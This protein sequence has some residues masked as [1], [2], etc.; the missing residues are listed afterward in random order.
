MP[1]LGLELHLLFPPTARVHVGAAGAR[2]APSPA[3]HRHYFRREAIYHLVWTAPV[4]EVA[5]RLGV[6]DVALAKLCRRAAIPTPG[7]GYW[8]RTEAGQPVDPTPLGM[9]PTSQQRELPKFSKIGA[10]GRIARGNAAPPPLRSGPPFG[11][12]NRLRR[13]VELPRA[14]GPGSSNSNAECPVPWKG[15]LTL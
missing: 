11:R 9:A 15:S 12:P 3:L 7:R 4:A 5:E 10:P 13:F 1:D 8:Q 14:C 6:S 2:P